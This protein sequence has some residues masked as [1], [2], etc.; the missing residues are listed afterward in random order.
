M[1]RNSV[2]GLLSRGGTV[3]ESARCEEMY[4]PHGPEAA[5]DIVKRWDIDGLVVIGG[6]GSFRGAIKIEDCGVPVVGL[7]GTIDNDIPGTER[8]IGF[9]TAC[10]TFAWCLDQLRDT[11][12]SHHRTFVVEAM[13]RH[14]GWLALYGGLA[15]G[16]DVILI[17]EIP[18]DKEDVLHRLQTRIEEGRTFHLIVIAEGAGRAT[19]LAG[20][21]QQQ[22]PVEL[23]VRT[24][25][26]GHIQRG[27]QPSTL[28]RLFATRCGHQATEAL[29]DGRHR[30][31]IGEKNSKIIEA[32]LDQAVEGKRKIN[33]ELYNLALVV[34]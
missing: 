32:P 29:V 13:G 21:L 24:C 34:S 14:T 15:G 11:A 26:P 27:G 7:P 5:A 22:T 2:S 28:D 20:Y 25:I 17:P 12:A 30:I 1:D 31:M 3:I 10:D 9:D 33:E 23:E 18:W 19:E 4:E 8:T 16:A 6:D